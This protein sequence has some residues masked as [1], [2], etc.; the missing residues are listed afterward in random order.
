MRQDSQHQA[1]EV[2]MGLQDRERGCSNYHLGFATRFTTSVAVIGK[3]SLDARI[4]EFQRF[5][6]WGAALGFS[7][8]RI[9][10]LI[11]FN[12]FVK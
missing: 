3:Q 9:F 12:D 6:I 10:F 2:K 5:I 11:N 1:L 8:V 4:D 7:W